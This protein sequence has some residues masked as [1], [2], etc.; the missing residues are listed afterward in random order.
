MSLISQLQDKSLSQPRQKAWCN[1]EAS[2]GTGKREGLEADTA[3][4]SSSCVTAA[5][6]SSVL[7]TEISSL[8]SELGVLSKK[9][10]RQMEIMCEVE[11]YILTKVKA[12]VGAFRHYSMNSID[13]VQ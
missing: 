13:R 8:Q 4:C 1:E 6:K 10:Q 2:N 12:D 7:D 3:K 5:S 11:R 9:T